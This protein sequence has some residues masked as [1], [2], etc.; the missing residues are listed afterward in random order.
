MEAEGG[1]TRPRRRTRSAVEMDGLRVPPHSVEAEQAVLGGLL[2]DNSTWDAIADRLRGEDFYRRDHQLIFNG[3]AELSARAEP[4][5]AVTLAEYL[6]SQGHA[7]Q[8]GGLAYLAGLARDTP[9]A[10][11]VRAYADIVRERAL[12]RQLI[13]VS[14]EVAASAYDSEGRTATELVDEAERRVFEIAEQG[15]RTG[16]GFVPIR[17]VLGADHRPPRHAAPEPGA[18][19]RR[20]HRLPRPRPDDRRPAAGRPDRRRGT[21]VDGQDH[22]RAQHRRERGDFGAQHAGGRVF[23]WKCRASSCRCA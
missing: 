3:I 6:A 19:H 17:E 21:P 22:V 2:L 16:S 11:N 5:D 20:Q 9:T 1:G 15:R 8:T 13:R 4:S 14:G 12:L 10:A 7:D 23:A 18:A